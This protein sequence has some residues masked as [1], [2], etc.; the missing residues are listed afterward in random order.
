MLTLRFL[1][2]FIERFLLK[3]MWMSLFVK[4]GNSAYV[5][6]VIRDPAGSLVGNELYSFP[7]C[8]VT[9]ADAEVIRLGIKDLEVHEE[10][11]IEDHLFGDLKFM[12]IVDTCGALSKSNRVSNPSLILL[13]S[14]SNK[15]DLV[16]VSIGEKL[17]TEPGVVVASYLIE[18]NPS[19]QEASPLMEVA[20]KVGMN[21][22]IDSVPQVEAPPLPY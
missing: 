19:T 16:V 10:V 13:S 18:I 22:V 4:G 20:V 17:I 9:V 11:V 15:L 1:G 7:V 12:D 5:V 14:K 21:M 6:V 8:S 2:L 3:L